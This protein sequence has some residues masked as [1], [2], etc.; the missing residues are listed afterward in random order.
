MTSITNILPNITSVILN[1]NLTSIHN[2]WSCFSLPTHDNL[3]SLM[4]PLKT[5]SPLDPIP[6]D[7]LRSL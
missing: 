5:N 1:L 4:I 6:F 7:I 3:L 2:H